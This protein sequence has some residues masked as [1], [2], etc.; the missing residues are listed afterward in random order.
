MSESLWQELTTVA[1][2][3]T[4][5]KSYA[6]L[7]A[8]TSLDALVARLQGAD[9]EGALL[10][11][12][13]A[14]A[15]HRR[16]GRR[17]E[18]DEGPAPAPAAAEDRAPC[19]AVARE[20]LSLILR[21][22][23]PE[24][25]PEWL[26][27]LAATSRRVPV[28]SLPA[29]L[30]LGRQ[31]TELRPAIA[32]VIGQRGR[33]LAEQNPDWRWVAM[34]SRAHSD[35]DSG[36]PDDAAWETGS[37]SDRLGVLVRL[38]AVNPARARELLSSTWDR[39]TREDRA[40]FVATFAQGL[41]IDDE[42]FLESALDD[43]RK[44]VRTAAAE[45]LARLPES[46]LCGRV[47]A[48]VRPLLAISETSE[49]T[50]SVPF[51]E[52]TLPTECDKP[53]ARDGIEPKPGR[54][55]FGERAWWLLQMLAAIPPPTW[56]AAWGRTPKEIVTSVLES[57]WRSALLQG[58]SRAALR[59]RDPTWIESLLEA[60]PRTESL[61]DVTEAISIL[62]ADARESALLRLLRSKDDPAV[63]A[64]TRG[65]PDDGLTLLISYRQ[66]WGEALSS[67]FLEQIWSALSDNLSQQ[68]YQLLSVLPA[69]GL[70]V[71]PD[72]GL[73]EVDAR[74]E[75]IAALDPWARRPLEN[76]QALLQFRAD[77]LEELYA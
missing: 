46:R 50:P 41:G 65:V 44:E 77:M 3:G 12:A 57:E 39:E 13:A 52:L 47:L 48:R 4:E 29:L 34:T 37:R 69:A 5:R 22:S 28:E 23:Y 6:P 26:E 10:A 7:G 62:P 56:T 63:L 70:R 66:P 21:G 43:R 16:A 27:A 33:W 61:I 60:A 64:G 58:L 38:R 32:T 31:R 2:L 42:P 18:M 68:T 73:R 35:T 20:H 49:P 75:A 1:L 40:D 72:F 9:R 74:S 55:G 25:L 59:H 71:P 24:T 30:D 8:N 36:F 51:A 17:P 15:V 67:Y 14:V 19:S 53:M 76:F 45:L 54:S 11:V